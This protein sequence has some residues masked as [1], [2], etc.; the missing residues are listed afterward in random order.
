MGISDE[1]HIQKY[2]AI[3]HKYKWHGIV[4]AV[5]V[6][7]LLAVGSSFLPKVYESKCIVEVE[8]GS[9]ENPLRT[10]REY[11]PP[12]REQLHAFSESALSW[13]ALSP[14]LDQIGPEKIFENSDVYNIQK[15]KAWLRGDAHIA[16]DTSE[17]GALVEVAAGIL[18]DGIVIRQRPPRFLVLTY[19]GTTPQVNADVLNTLVT[20]MIEELEKAEISQVGRSYKFLKSEMEN[21]RGKLEEAETR[22][23][24]FREQH[25]AELPNNINIHLTQLTHDQTE[26]MSCDLEMKEL[27]T[28]LRYID[29]ALENQ[30]ALIV[31]EIRREA[32]PIL[33]V[34][35]ER[36]VD[37]E[38]ELTRL[39]TNYT[40]LHPSV[41]EL[42]GQLGDLKKQEEEVQQSTVDTETSMLNPIHQR[43][44]EDR[45]E[46]LLRIE[47]LKSRTE[48]LEK[49]IAENE[50]RVR[51]VPAQEQELVTLTRNYEVT[52]NIYNMFLQRLEE[53]KI[54][55]KLATE[56]RGRESFRVLQQARVTVT[57][58]APDGLKVLLAILMLGGAV[59]VGIMLALDLFD[60]SLNDIEDAKELIKKPLLGTI[61]F[62]KNGNGRVHLRSSLPKE[63]G[64]H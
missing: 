42:K 3:F 55:E 52:A 2:I 48:N 11:S 20:G 12:L 32:N 9:I 35:S 61:P 56:E 38:I 37:M 49:R 36:I 45:Q 34:L 62:L 6:M 7:A 51:S 1:L 18:R 39:R 16:R 23:R 28:R 29:E 26:L 54:Q 31:S 63:T 4:P 60:D 17:A 19:Q 13:D 5:V 25:S 8:R 14:V 58:V 21:Y 57:P 27:T 30:K 24:E 59:C 15:F 22:L 50:E 40:D 46:T 53:A 10:R 41:I 64:K 33:V 47:V 43:L 44:T